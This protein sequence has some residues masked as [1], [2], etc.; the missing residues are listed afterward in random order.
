M[1]E[2]AVRLRNQRTARTTEISRPNHRAGPLPKTTVPLKTMKKA[3]PCHA[4]TS[5]R[6]RR[7]KLSGASHHQ[8]DIDQPGQAEQVV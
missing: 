8:K 2:E 4:A 7:A 1:T 5:Q 3:K 6:D